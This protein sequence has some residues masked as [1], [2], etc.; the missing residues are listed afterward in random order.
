MASIQKNYSIKKKEQT[1]HNYSC[2][3]ENLGSSCFVNAALQLLYQCTL[4]N[5]LILQNET[6]LNG[7]YINKYRYFLT[8]YMSQNLITERLPIVLVNYTNRQDDTTIPLENII[9]NIIEEVTSTAN[10]NIYKLVNGMPLD[11][12]IDKLFY[13][14]TTEIITCSNCHYNNHKDNQN[15]IILRLT[16]PNKTDIPI[17]LD[18]LINNYSTLEYPQERIC[19]NCSNVNIGANVVGKQHV[20]KDTS[21]Y[22]IISLNRYVYIDEKN[23]EKILTEV[24]MPLT[25]NFQLTSGIIKKYDLRGYIYHKGTTLTSG[26]YV[27]YG[28]KNGKFVSHDDLR[29][30]GLNNGVRQNNDDIYVGKGNEYKNTG[31]VYLYVCDSTYNP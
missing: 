10:Y 16:L 18:K 26:H 30:D 9:N 21:K 12:I 3:I 8:K 22:L 27:Y 2:G 29:I 15:D 5:R 17:P 28:M 6:I 31:Y 19:S 14:K 23:S 13:V 11:K 25:Y 4:L 20:F 7:D 1:D 24:D